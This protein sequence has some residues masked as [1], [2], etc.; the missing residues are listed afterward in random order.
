MRVV[1]D[2]AD[3]VVR[4]TI[5]ARTYCDAVDDTP[6]PRVGDRRAFGHALSSVMRVRGMTQKALAAQLDGMAQSAI[7]AWVNGDAAPLH[8]VVFEVERILQVP[9]GFLSRHL[10]YG[11]VDG[12]LPSSVLDAIDDDPLLDDVQRQALATLYRAFTGSRSATG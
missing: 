7:S 2:H 11:P 3:H 1:L 6:R 9:G 12:A 8:E 10:G 5:R 4:G